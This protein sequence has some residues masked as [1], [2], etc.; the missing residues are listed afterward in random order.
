L[1]LIQWRDAFRTRIAPVDFE[2]EQ[3]VAL[4]NRLHARLEAA[5]GRR[6]AVA[7]FLGELHDRIAAHFALEERLMRERS[8]AEY[9]GHKD[10]HERLLDEIREIMEEHE[11]G[12]FENATEHLA[13][14]IEIWFSRHFHTFDRRLHEA[15]P[16]LEG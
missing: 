5:G 12:R 4:I 9:A 10:D 1:T 3:L 6:E 11:Q 2:H 16:G 13:E 15:K 8:H 14:R 7:A